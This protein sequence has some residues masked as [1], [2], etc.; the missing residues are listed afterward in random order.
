MDAENNTTEEVAT[1]P[2]D[3]VIAARPSDAMMAELKAKHKGL[4]WVVFD[5]FKA[6]VRKPRIVDLERAMKASKVPGASEMAFNKNLVANCT[7]YKDAGY[8]DDEDRTLALLTA[9]GTFAAIRE[10]TIVKA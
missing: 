5:G 8:D 1:G 6:L 9:V 4:Q 3:E 10:A 2:S 7:V